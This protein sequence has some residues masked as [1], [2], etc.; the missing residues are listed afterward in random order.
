MVQTIRVRPSCLPLSMRVSAGEAMPPA[1]RVAEVVLAGTR[2][3]YRLVTTPTRSQD[4]SRTASIF[5]CPGKTRLSRRPTAANCCVP[6]RPQSSVRDGIPV[7]LSKGPRTV[8]GR[9]GGACRGL[10]ESS[11]Y[12]SGWLLFR[13]VISIP[14]L[15]RPASSARYAPN[16][17]APSKVATTHVREPD[18]STA[19]RHFQRRHADTGLRISTACRHARLGRHVGHPPALR[20][21]RRR[22]GQPCPR[23]RRSTST[24]PTR[25]PRHPHALGLQPERLAG[26]GA[27]A[28]V[29]ARV[30]RRA[31]RVARSR[32]RARDPVPA[33]RALPGVKSDNS[34]WNSYPVCI[35]VSSRTASHVE[36][37]VDVT[38]STCPCSSVSRQRRSRSV[39]GRLRR[40]RHRRCREE[41]WLGT[42]QHRR[43]AAQ[44][45][46]RPCRH[47]PTSGRVRSGTHRPVRVTPR[48]GRGRGS[49]DD[50]FAPLNGQNPMFCEDLPQDHARLA[51]HH[52]EDFWVRI[53]HHENPH[54]EMPAIARQVF[55]R[56]RASSE[57]ERVRRVRADAIARARRP[58][59]RQRDRS[60]CRGEIVDAPVCVGGNQR[61]KSLS[62]SSRRFHLPTAAAAPEGPSGAFP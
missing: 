49:V 45:R 33:H 52:V 55:R 4:R 23:R 1:R 28:G 5:V 38:T 48:P 56:L 9:I 24:S 27:A 32:P 53:N 59:P 37:G 40:E 29:A 11:R 62:N 14:R 22:C 30:A 2:P 34:G 21:P 25:K 13:F 61:F 57:R 20:D 58:D 16:R 46:R 36:P 39:R 41:A 43:H 17:F 35:R 15:P 3:P 7:L 54:A 19:R 51:R 18:M 47:R 44:P 60:G 31:A 12:C 10:I 6:Q 26:G 8:R 50:E 42:E